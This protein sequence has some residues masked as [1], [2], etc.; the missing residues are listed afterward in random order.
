MLPTADKRHRLSELDALR[1]IGALAVVIFHYTTRFHEKF[2]D[3]PHVPFNFIGGNYRVLLFFAISGFAIF[4]TLDKVKTAP[5]FILNRFSRL[6]PAYWVAMLLTLGFEY[7]GGVTVLQVPPVA[8]LANFSMLE[9][10]VFMPAVDGA[11]WTLTVEIGFYASMLMLWMG[12]GAR[13]LEP[14]LLLWLACKWLLYLWPA[15]MPERLVMLMVLR[16]IPFFAIGMLSYRVWAGK[17]RWS[18]Q[19]P[20]LAAVLLTIAVCETRD[21]LVMGLLLVACFWAMVEGYLAFLCVRPLLW[22]GSISYSFYLVHQNIGFVVMLKAAA[23]GLNPWIGFFLA[24]AVAVGLGALIN[25]YVERPAA[26]M[27]MAWW[28]GRR[29]KPQA[30]APAV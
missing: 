7:L 4:F 12:P 11:Y 18:Q 23:A 25:H 8:I 10:F 19:L 2:P 14:L 15:M 3:A 5:D 1:G 20:Y 13:R 9:G 24:I 16:Y 22:F 21:L 27:I 28:N 26:R 6:Y 29:R 30:P 17:R